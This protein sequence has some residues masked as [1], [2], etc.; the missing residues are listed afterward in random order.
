MKRSFSAILFFVL[1]FAAKAQF[2]YITNN[3]AITITKYTGSGGAVV[4]PATINGLLVTSIGTNAFYNNIS[5]TSVTIGT[6]VTSIGGQAFADCTSLKSVT[7]GSGVS[8]IGGGAFFYCT[9]LTNVTVPNSVTNIGIGAFSVCTKLTNI[10]VAVSNPAYSSLNGVLFDKAQTTLFQFPGGLGGSYIIPSSVT[11]IGGQAFGSTSLT[12]VTIPNCVANI[13]DYAFAY[14]NNLAAYFQGNAP[15]DDGTIFYNDT[16]TT[17]YYLAGTTGWVSTFGGVAA[18][19][20]SPPPPPLTYTTNSGAIT[21][22][23]YT[24]SG[25]AVVIPALINGHPVTTIGG[26]A[27]YFCTSLT[28]VTIPNSVT[29]I[30]SSAFYYCTGL[31]N[32]TVAAYDPAYSSVNGVLFDNAQATLIQFPGGLGGNYTI[33]NNVTSIGADAFYYCTNLTSVT[34]GNNVTNIGVL[35]FYFCKRLTS[36]TVGNGVTN[37]GGQMFQG[38]SS[39]T[40]ITIPNGVT[41]IGG[42]AFYYCTS[43]TSVTIP[44]SV[45]SIG[46]YAF[47][48]C[49]LTSVMIPNSITSIGSGGFSDCGKLTNITVAA[50]NPAYSSLNGVLFDKAQATLIQFPGGLSGSYTVPSNVT[51]IGDYA[52]GS[53]FLKSITIP[54]SVTNIGERAFA[55]CNYL[56]AAYFQGNA[57]PDNGSAFFLDNLA[58]TTVYYLFGTTG[59]GSIF[60]GVAVVLWN[61]QAQTSDGNFGVQANQ[62]GFNITGS[63]GLVIVVQACTNLVNPIWLPVATNTLTS[64]TSYF[65]DPQWTNYP[66]RFYRLRSP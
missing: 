47:D 42:Q 57:P 15:P 17:A 65:S 1:A 13:G 36:V 12:S 22:T 27:F 61:P 28:S 30:G 63:S 34:I 4:I 66:G 53:C 2:Q 24:G 14:C 25:G 59:W 37:I 23:G 54:K 6:N 45:T 43:L 51:S 58:P 21:I 46:D 64:G 5:V 11:N 7:I 49:G 26:N 55:Y 60:G 32:F 33:P 62:F 48:S 50:S 18:V 20:F 29:N 10:T 41:S 16:H 40:N 52:F 8:N 19:L 9:S 3:G 56:S 38:C 39:L 35:A 44:N 31:T